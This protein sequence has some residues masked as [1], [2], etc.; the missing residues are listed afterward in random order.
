MNVTPGDAAACA[1]S[2]GF[3][4]WAVA[5]LA[6][7]R[8]AHSLERA[9]GASVLGAVLALGC[10]SAKPKQGAPVASSVATSPPSP[11]AATELDHDLSHGSHGSAGGA[12]GR[13]G[14]KVASPSSLSATARARLTTIRVSAHVGS[15]I[16]RREAGGWVLSGSDGCTVQPARLERAL[17]NL[18]ALKSVPT[19][20]PVPG[21]A[22]FRLQLTVLVGEE[23]AVHLDVADRNAK[24]HL[25]R[26]DDDS[27]VRIRGLDL[28]LWSPHPADW[29]K[30]P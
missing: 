12:G 17:D 5:G 15:V 24:G 20:E 29:C 30:A 4:R 13:K 11:S 23:P 26:L 14:P 6:S 25:A 28:G 18:A 19:N 9:F 16:I 27:M 21:G 22:A 8:R 3:L 7:P 1:R 10:Q 2:A